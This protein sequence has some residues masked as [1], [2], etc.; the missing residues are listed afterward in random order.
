[1]IDIAVPTSR[2]NVMFTP[3][4]ERGDDREKQ[5]NMTVNRSW[6]H[7]GLIFGTVDV[8]LPEWMFN[9]HPAGWR[10]ALPGRIKESV[11]I[12]RK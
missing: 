1:M 6:A 4:G 12:W 10:K 7:F 2:V 8:V 3:S 5:R 11:L 9:A